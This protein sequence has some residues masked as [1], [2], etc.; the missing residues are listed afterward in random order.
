MDRGAW[1]AAVHGV[2]KEQDTTQQPNSNKGRNQQRDSMETEELAAVVSAVLT[3]YWQPPSRGLM[4]GLLYSLPLTPQQ[5]TT[6][7]RLC[8]RLL[9]THSKSGSVSLG[10]LLLSPG[11]WCARGFA[12]ALQESASPVVR[13]FC[14]KSHRPSKSN[15]LE[16]LSP[17]ARSP[18]WEICCGS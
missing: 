6:D 17:F 8:W 13:K 5:A 16:V 14:N 15:S 9:D 4:P 11:S 18:G 12:C 10:P 3:I 1:Q 7:P 2:T